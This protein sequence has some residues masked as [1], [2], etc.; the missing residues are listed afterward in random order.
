MNS[1]LGLIREI[2]RAYANGVAAKADL[3]RSG[4][5]LISLNS[6]TDLRWLN[7][8][9][10]EH[11]DASVSADEVQ[12]MIEVFLAH[13]RMPRMELF[14]ELWPE[15]IAL[16]LEMGFEIESELP[17]MICT[18]DGFISQISPGVT[19]EVLTPDSDPVPFLK[20]LDSAFGQNEPVTPERIERTRDSLRRGAV[21]SAIALVDGRPAAGA[22]LIPSDRTAELAGVGT[23]P[24]F[25]RK[26]AASAVSSVLLQ[27]GFGTC[28]LA[29]LSAGDDTAKAVYER[30]GFKVLGTQVNISK[31]TLA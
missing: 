17:V 23:A 12:S 24:E 25:R 5:F 22:S 7:N 26:G 27:Q 19:V 18:P 2:E 10:V 6:S 29:W 4:P 3:I 9:V 30:L 21:W 14:K 16:L 1:S 11:A 28:D 31:P 15:L 8:A 13:Q 20:V